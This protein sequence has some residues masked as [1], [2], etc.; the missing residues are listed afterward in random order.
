MNR[1]LPALACCVASAAAAQA[2]IVHDYAPAADAPQTVEMRGDGRCTTVRPGDTV[3]YTLSIDNVI[4]ARAVLGDLHLR[5]GHFR[6]VMTHAGLPVADFRSLGGGG[7][8]KRDTDDARQYQFAFV[9]P[10]QIYSGTYRG[11]DVS[12]SAHE[13]TAGSDDPY[14]EYA[15]P[16]LPRPV[17]HTHVH[18]TKRTRREVRAYC[19]N[20][21]STFGMQQ[22]AR[23]AVVAFAPGSVDPAPPR[24]VTPVP[25]PLPTQPIPIP[26]QP[27]PQ[28]R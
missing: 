5:P 15:A 14:A 27:V 9:V 24:P 22:Q 23:A 7:V 13:L 10:E 18:V 16:Y 2:P 17:E 21:M 26:V 3:H 28:P 11:V 4:D 6:E 19:L 25:A 20:V 12:V 8:G 1:L